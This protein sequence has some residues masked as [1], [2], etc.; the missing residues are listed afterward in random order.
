MTDAGGRLIAM[1][2]R[3]FLG[4]ASAAMVG[5]FMLLA[6]RSAVAMQGGTMYGRIGKMVALS[7]QRDALAAILFGSSQAMP[8]C[9]SYV[10]ATDPADHD[11][12]WI[13]EVW[14]SAAS[15]KK[16]LTLPAVQ[17]AIRERQ[18]THRR[19]RQHSGDD[20]DR[21]LRAAKSRTA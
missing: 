17:A 7:G 21:R 14:D 4:R 9:L 5:R 10:I 13:T 16:S 20:A 2:R 1:F 18:T 3:N 8:G 11:A 19:L 6:P 12:L 15:H